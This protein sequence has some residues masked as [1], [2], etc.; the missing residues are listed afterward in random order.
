MFPRV[1]S[2]HRWPRAHLGPGVSCA[3]SGLW[4]VPPLIKDLPPGRLGSMGNPTLRKGA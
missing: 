2:W 3:T 4:S 1:A